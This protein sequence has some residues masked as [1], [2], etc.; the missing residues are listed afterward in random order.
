LNARAV[1]QMDTNFYRFILNSPSGGV[2]VVDRTGQNRFL[3]ESA[4]RVTGHLSREVLGHRCDEDFLEHAASENSLLR[5][6]AIATMEAIR[7]VP[8]FNELQ[9][10]V[11]MP[12]QYRIAHQ[13]DGISRKHLFL[14]RECTDEPGWRRDPEKAGRGTPQTA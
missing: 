12:G 6:H 3:D 1:P 9:N 10:G 5:G 8:K 4:E 2:G 14:Q 7:E 13:T 11:D